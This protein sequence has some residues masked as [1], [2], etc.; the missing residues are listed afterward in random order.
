MYELVTFVDRFQREKRPPRVRLSPNGAIVLNRSA[1]EMFGD[2][3][4]RRFHV[5]YDAQSEVMALKPATEPNSHHAYA[6][7]LIQQ[8]RAGCELRP[9]SFWRAYG[10]CVT[11]RYVA[12]PVLMDRTLVIPL[13]GAECEATVPRTKSRPSMQAVNLNT[14]GGLAT[15]GELL[16]AERIS[17]RLSLRH[18]SAL[19]DDGGV[20]LSA[21][22]LVRIEQGTLR[23][24]P[25]P[26]TLAGLSTVLGV[27]VRAW[28]SSL[29]P[30][31]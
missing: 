20:K 11:K 13:S 12:T 3:L 15:F 29:Y 5:Q 6:A 19:L 26:E 8:G 9:T 25:R 28:L 10:L 22:S 18:L 31:K 17:A 21:P 1:W 2:P 30:D 23:R 14:T 24:P 4:P 7:M 27:P 16:R